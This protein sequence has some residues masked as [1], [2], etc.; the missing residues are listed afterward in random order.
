[1]TSNQKLIFVNQKKKEQH[2][3]N[4]LMGSPEVREKVIQQLERHIKHIV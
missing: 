3:I 4:T 1:M 2:L